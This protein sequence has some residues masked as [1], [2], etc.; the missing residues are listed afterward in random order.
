MVALSATLREPEKFVNWIAST[1]GRPGE[2]VIRTDRHVPLHFGG[3]SNAKSAEEAE[4]VEMFGTHGDRKNVFFQ[5]RFHEVFPTAAEIQKVMQAQKQANAAA[6][7]ARNTRNAELLAKRLEQTGGVMPKGSKGQAAPGRAAGGSGHGKEFKFNFVNEVNRLVTALDAQDK[8]PAIV[9]CM[10][11][12]ACVKA[13]LAV[14]GNP[15][16]GVKRKKPVVAPGTMSIELLEWE[17][18]EAERSHR[19]REIEARRS[20]MHRK[21][22]QRFSSQLKELEAYHELDALLKRGIAYH[23]AGMLPI[24]REFVELCFQERLI[25]VVFATETLAVG[26][27]M[28]ARTVVFTQLDKPD[29]QGGGHRWCR[30]D[31]F[32]Q[33]AGRAGRRGMDTRG[34]VVYAPTLSVAGEKNRVPIYELNRML[35]GSMPSA[36]SQIVID[37]SFVLRHL[38]KVPRCDCVC[39]AARRHRPTVDMLSSVVRCVQGFGAEVLEATLLADQVRRQ[40]AVLSAEGVPDEPIF[41]HISFAEAVEKY[42]ELLQKLEG[43]DS[44][45]KL[46]PKQRKATELAMKEIVTTYSHE[47]EDF[48]TIRSRFIRWREQQTE[49]AKL[50]SQLRKDWDKAYK[51]LSEFG[52]VEHD[53][54]LGP[55]DPGGCLLSL[56]TCLARRALDRPCVGRCK[57]AEAGPTWLRMFG[58]CRWTPAHFG[59]DHRRRRPCKARV[60]RDLCLVSFFFVS[61][62]V[63]IA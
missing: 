47:G 22:L 30:C 1:R 58:V 28:P 52:F 27:N 11:R 13:A 23:H 42:S 37:E 34:F 54:N 45:I 48:E 44:I 8:L 60:C 38:G 35:T 19:V 5:E 55:P 59:D 4:F 62:S 21:H 33:M 14:H 57:G 6:S 2:I 26:V 24:L 39:D 29:N 20:A 61:H 46:N 41:T 53:W 50:T 16:F 10:S 43:T 51:W 18:E 12:K 15:L 56:Q 32:W 40:G 36:E 31:E 63:R 25:R 9:F 3:L 17:E 49:A 7:D